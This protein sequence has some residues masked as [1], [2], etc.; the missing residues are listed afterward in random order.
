[1]L[2]SLATLGRCARRSACH[3]AVV[4][5]YSSLPLCVAA[6]RRTS[7]EI[8]DPLARSRCRGGAM[9]RSRR[10]SRRWAR[11]MATPSL[12]Q[13][14]RGSAPTAGPARD[15][16]A[17]PPAFTE[18]AC[19]D[20]WGHTD[21]WQRGI[22]END[23]RPS[24]SVLRQSHRTCLGDCCTTRNS[25]DVALETASLGLPASLS[26]RPLPP[27]HFNDHLLLTCTRRCC[28]DHLNPPC[29]PRS[30]CT[31][32]SP[33][34]GCRRQRAISRASTTSSVRRWSAMDQPTI[35]RE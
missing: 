21:R 18:P 32:V 26:D 22:L 1:M 16:C 25:V 4:A 29:D 34:V 24:A 13:R 20:G 6:L 8:V 5:R 30:E 19:S 15:C 2:A 27:W 12:A 23:Q 17:S 7:R 10:R 11:R 14:T 35:R 28:D 3:C 9:T 31:T 33:R